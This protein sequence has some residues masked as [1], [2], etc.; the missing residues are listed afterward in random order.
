MKTYLQKF[1]EKEKLFT[2]YKQAK[3]THV[4]KTHPAENV[5]SNTSG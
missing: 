4:H 1:E 5:R 3:R 2:Q